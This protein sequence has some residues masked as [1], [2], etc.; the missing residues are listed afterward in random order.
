MAQIK[1]NGSEM[2]HEDTA[3]QKLNFKNVVMI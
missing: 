2:K 3:C 1:N